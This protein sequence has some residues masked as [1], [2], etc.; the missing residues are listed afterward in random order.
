M[1][2]LDTNDATVKIPEEIDADQCKCACALQAGG[3]EGGGGTP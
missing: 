3:G 1:K 2:I